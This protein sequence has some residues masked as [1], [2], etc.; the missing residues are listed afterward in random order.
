MTIGKEH[1]H[2]KPSYAE[3]RT[4]AHGLQRPQPPGRPEISE[5][6]LPS[7]YCQPG[8]PTS[9]SMTS[10]RLFKLPPLTDLFLF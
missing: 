2:G 6:S 4:R 3:G 9:S 7:R 10:R 1:D 5:P 8:G